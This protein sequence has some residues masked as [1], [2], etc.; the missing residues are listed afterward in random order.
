MF[1]ETGTCRFSS[2]VSPRVGFWMPRPLW[3]WS[4]IWTRVLVF[5]LRFLAFS[6][7]I[8]TLTICLAWH[9][10]NRLDR[11]PFSYHPMSYLGFPCNLSFT[12]STLILELSVFILV[13]LCNGWF[14]ISMV[15]TPNLG[16]EIISE[17]S[18]SYL[19]SKCLSIV[20]RPYGNPTSYDLV[21]SVV[22]V[23]KDLLCTIFVLSPSRLTGL[24]FTNRWLDRTICFSILY[25]DDDFAWVI[26]TRSDCPIGAPC[27]S[28]R[29]R[30]HHVFYESML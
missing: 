1:V 24:P 17:S 4:E 23:S 22:F 20:W 29:E 16:E 6:L 26:S 14:S 15:S 5:L 13:Y 12:I 28:I 27:V 2:S 8:G 30:R 3:S 10:G 25:V 9:Y 21:A 7:F 19:F 11:V 18:S